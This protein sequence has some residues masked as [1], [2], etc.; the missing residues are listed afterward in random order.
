MIRLLRYVSMLLLVAVITGCTATTALFF[1]P[2]RQWISTPAD[3]GLEYADVMLT[4]KDGTRLH[5]W[6]IPA[7]E[8]DTGIA[9]LYLHG[10]AEN[11]SSHSRSIYWLAKAG[12][13]VLALDY[14]G[15]GASEGAAVM[16]SVLQDIQATAQWL[17]TEQPDKRLVVLGQSIGAALAIDFVAVYGPEFQVQALVVDAPFSGFGGAARHALSQSWIGWLIWPFT[18]LVPGDWN[19][20]DFV[21]RIQV[22]VLMMSS[23]D[24]KVVAHDDTKSL[25]KKL[26]ARSGGEASCWLQSRG[27]HIASFADETIRHETLNFIKTGQ[28]PPLSGY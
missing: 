3:A 13:S 21:R 11:I 5:S 6:W 8:D 2:Q 7:A 24:D 23:P 28:C 22:P 10:N 14:R 25:Y 1:Y 9:V 15:F 19:P 17:R 26:T 27:R 18:V 16:P 12:V 4:A 20:E